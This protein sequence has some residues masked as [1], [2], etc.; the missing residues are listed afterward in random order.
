M[1]NPLAAMKDGERVRFGTEYGWAC[2]WLNGRPRPFIMAHT[3]SRTRTDAQTI[4]GRAWK[5]PGED[6]RAGWKRAYREGC[7]CIRVSVSPSHGYGAL[8]SPASAEESR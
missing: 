6:W 5:R 3:T 1:T 8:P 4:I 7:R 2:A